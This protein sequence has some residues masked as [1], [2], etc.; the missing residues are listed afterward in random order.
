MKVMQTFKLVKC[1]IETIY[2]KSS[3][4]TKPK[5]ISV[6]PSKGIDKVKERVW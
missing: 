4:M 2:Q 3:F 5:L 1:E 6:L